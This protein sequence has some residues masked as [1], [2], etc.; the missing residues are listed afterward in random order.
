MPVKKCESHGYY[1]GET[2]ECGED[3]ELIIPDNKLK[4]L[5]KI[6]S[7]ALRHFPKDIGVNLDQN[8]W[9][10]L[11]QLLEAISSRSRYD[12]LTKDDLIAL[13]E[14]DKKGR[15]EIEDNKIR[16]TYGHTVDVSPDLPKKEPPEELYYGSS[17]EEAG[18][19]EEIGLKPVNKNK[20]HLSEESESALEVAQASIDNP[21]LIVVKA[22]D[23]YKENVDIR[24][25]AKSLWVAPEIPPEFLE[26]KN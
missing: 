24:K 8:G 3:G 15:Y 9:A 25:A 23:V 10:D 13:V 5:G 26:I 22:K 16:A 2:C 20:V 18:R 17:E 7:G 11:D 6:V 12:W 1:R 4:P 21:V 14:T 19:V